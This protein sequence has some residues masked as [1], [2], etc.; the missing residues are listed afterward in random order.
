MSIVLSPDQ[1]TALDTVIQTLNTNREAILA[2]AAGTGKT[3]VMSVVLS[4]WPGHVLFLAPT[5]KA[6]VRLAEQVQRPARTIHSAIYGMAEEKRVKGSRRDTLAFG[7][8]TSPEECGPGTLVVIDEASMVNT[9]LANDVRRVILDT[10][11]AL[12]WVGDHEQLAPVEGGWGVPLHRA[13]ARLTQ[14]HRQALESPVLELATLIRNREG[15]K[16][17]RW[18]DECSR[19]SI[20]QVKEAVD[21]AEEKP[22]DRILMTWTN[23][24]RS[25]ANRLTREARNLPKKEIVVGER[26]ICTY[27]N[28]PLGF[29]NGEVMVVEHVEDC[30]TLTKA[31]AQ[32]VAWV[33]FAGKP[34]RVLMAPATFDTY[35]PYRSDRQLFRDV[36]APLFSK[37]SAPA[38]MAEQGW[39]VENLREWRSVVSDFSLMGTW[40]YCITVH[41]AQG[42]QYPEVGFI[43]CPAFRQSVANGGRMSDE[44][45]RRMSYTAVTRAQFRFRAFTLTIPNKD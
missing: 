32:R 23:A 16:F 17:N 24:T 44:D 1:Q 11:A 42:S 33:R 26:L 40:A 13:T 25:K 22:D 5:G 19:V 38:L 21:W 34:N 4:R 45:R 20:T 10:G 12:L 6:A 31:L 14:V 35:H 41:K 7:E 37:D 29:M 18:G 27:N 2:G 15:G 30:V 36:W 8:P 3:T 43:S 9:D 39:S 28:H